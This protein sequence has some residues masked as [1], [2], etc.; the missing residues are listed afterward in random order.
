[1][2]EMTRLELVDPDNNHNKFWQANVRGNVVTKQWGR[3]GSLGQ[4]KVDNFPSKDNAYSNYLREIEG[5]ERK[6]YKRV[7]EKKYGTEE[8]FTETEIDVSRDNLRLMIE[9]L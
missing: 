1:M 7:D 5:K 8:R 2:D 6:G 4:T 9:N 3:I